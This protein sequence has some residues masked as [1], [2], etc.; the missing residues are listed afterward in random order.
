MTKHYLDILLIFLFALFFTTVN[1]Q[2]WQK[3]IIAEEGAR[4]SLALDNQGNVYVA[5]MLESNNG[6]VKVAVNNDSGFENSIVSS[7]YFYGPL[8][9]CTGSDNTVYIAY[10]DHNLADQ[11][12]AHNINPRM[13]DPKYMEAINTNPNL[14]TVVRKAVGITLKKH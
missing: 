14:E 12:V 1:G 5:Y 11:I 4:P 9:I 8:D 10:H 6:W 2:S 13:A 3:Q 7:G